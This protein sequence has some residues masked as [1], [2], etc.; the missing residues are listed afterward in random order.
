MMRSRL[1]AIVIPTLILLATLCLG[2]DLGANWGV[3]NSVSEIVE[4]RLGSSTDHFELHTVKPTLF[5]K[6]KNEESLIR[7]ITTE[8]GIEFKAATRRNVR[9]TPLRLDDP[10]RKK[11][12]V[13]DRGT[14]SVGRTAIMPYRRGKSLDALKLSN[15]LLATDVEGGLHGM[16]RENGDLL[17]SIDSFHTKPLISASGTK[18]ESISETLIVEPYKEG[19]IFYFNIYQGLQKLPV[20]IDHLISSSPMHLK[21]EVIIDELGTSIEDEKIYTGYRSTAMYTLNALTGEILSEFGPGTEN[22]NFKKE[23]EICV[24]K[25]FEMEECDNLLIIGKTTYHLGIHSTDGTTYNLTYSTWQQNSI[26]AHLN[27]QNSFSQDGIYIAPFRDKS[28]L[29]IDADFKIAKWVSSNFP[30]IVNGIFDIFKDESQDENILI[31]HPFKLPDD[32]LYKDNKVYLDQTKNRTWFALTSDNFPSL[33]DAA[34]TS[35]FCL[36]ERWR[37]PSIQNNSELFRTAVTGVHSL[38][39]AKYEEVNYKGLDMEETSS[40]PES[41]KLLIDPPS[42][43]RKGMQ[44][45]EGA[46]HNALEKY[47]SPG[48]LEAYRLKVQEQ[49][50]NE[51]FQRNQG[52]WLFALGG[53]LYRIVESGFVLLFALFALVVLQKFKIIPPIN[54]LL[55]R[56]GLIAAKN[57]KIEEV[58]ISDEHSELG[59]VTASESSASTL[60]LKVITSKVEPTPDSATKVDTNTT[61][62]EAEAGSKNSPSEGMEIPSA[63][64]KKRKRGSRGGKKLKRRPQHD[65][66]IEDFQSVSSLEFEHDLKSLTVSDKILGYG[67]SGTVVLQGNFQG[68]PVAVKRMLLDFC[69]LAS[70]EIK[71]LTESDDHPNVIRYYCSETTEKFLYIALELCSSTLEDLVEQKNT[72]TTLLKLQCDKD[73]ID[74]LYQITSGVAHLHSL[75]IIH[76]DIKPQNILV[77]ASKR[78]LIGHQTVNG[79]VRILISDFG[80]CKQLDAD[81]SSYRTN[82]TNVGGTSGWRAPELLDESTRKLIE[83]M[84]DAA[85]MNGDIVSS[86]ESFYDYATKQRLTRAI[87]IFSM[88]C[89]FYYVLSKGEHPFGSRYLREANIIN[90]NSN[91]S[92]LKKT[93]KDRSLV[94]EAN[95]LIVHMIDTDPLE[96]PTASNILNHPLFWPITKKLEFLLK[97]SDRFEIERRDPPSPLLLKLEAH[98][99]SVILNGDWTKKFDREFMEN[100]GKYRKYSG[101]KL[102]D[103][104][105]AL[106]NKHHHFMDLPED[107]AAV[108]GPVPDGFY[109]YFIK[110]FPN[111]L[112]IIYYVV[113][114]NFQDDQILSKYLE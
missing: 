67:S 5:R 79:N 90:G 104:L 69:D 15:L 24:S 32:E 10:Y 57:L 112:M 77:A 53:F 78:S 105:R 48:E 25:G 41:S 65:S 46:Q 93:L 73:L 8:T 107:L 58:K 76:R 40:L 19:S 47:I 52:S 50:A 94:V 18:N 51:I 29:A 22:R 108:M 97:V 11:R 20:S 56:G 113:R 81:Q 35:K 92:G 59:E 109:N 16:D 111:L 103:L 83:S 72:S 54:S 4:R 30:A 86:T 71:L 23:S 44:K 114:E 26:D 63:E 1:L 36:S 106:R 68:R 42:L 28:V 87:D 91:L 12:D 17:W 38:V 6:N 39:N 96:R 9:P 99:G 62:D 85:Q 74:I 61:E 64:K 31:P 82:F 66:D 43:D 75:K 33:V 21:T 45:S 49:I 110:R 13:V 7:S 70:Q 34:P 27:L 14:L 100:L 3:Y 55:E 84:A 37:V 98:S 101:C 60:P 88:G 89:V 2:S 102:M 80:L 95:D